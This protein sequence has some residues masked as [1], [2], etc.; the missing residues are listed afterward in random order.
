[1]SMTA[2][3]TTSFTG[4][5]AAL[6]SKAALATGQLFP[7]KKSTVSRAANRPRRAPSARDAQ[8]A[9][10]QLRALEKEIALLTSY[11]GDTVYRLHYGTM[12]YDY[13]SPAVTKLLGFT[14]E[15]MKRINFRSLIVETK[16]V[17]NGMRVVGSFDE[18]E[19]M[20]QKGDV[21]KWQADYLMRTKDNGRVWV[22]DVSHPWFDENG[23]VIGSVGS[24]RDI[25]DR[26]EVESSIREEL[27]SI[28]QVDAL[29]GLENRREFF[30]D[31]EREIRRVGRIGTELSLMLVNVDKFHELNTAFS[32]S[33]G[34]KVLVEVSQ[35]LAG[36][37]RETD[38]VYRLDGEQFAVV[39]PDT[40]VHGAVVAG[41]RLRRFIADHGFNLGV[42]NDMQCTVSIGVASA[43]P[44]QEVDASAL[45]KLADT[46]LYIALNSGYN[47]I[48]V[49][50]VRHTH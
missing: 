2:T 16:M 12:S 37:L 27:E 17:T 43:I 25:T 15:E 21:G 39:L 13:I 5:K 1:M 38:M 47:Q 20:R 14:P 26:V 49:D 6:S 41:D 29:T 45:F 31:L 4:R 23:Q 18:L 34:E 42:D 3:T 24:L 7:Q 8:T 9:Q 28:S 50:E 30:R 32:V 40:T 46:R 33:A 44:G 11:S 36:G 22:S 19:T 48:A 10:P 35:L